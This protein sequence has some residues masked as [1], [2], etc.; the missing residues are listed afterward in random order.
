MA[1]GATSSGTASSSAKATAAQHRRR[2]ASSPSSSS[3]TPS[4][5][6]RL[7]VPVVVEQPPHRD[8]EPCELRRS[9]RWAAP[10]RSTSWAAGPDA[11]ART[12]ADRGARGAME[13]LPP[14]ER[15]ERLNDAAGGDPAGSCRPRRSSSSRAASRRGASP[16]AAA[17]RRCSGTCCAPA[18][19]R[20][21]TRGPPSAGRAR[22]RSPGAA[23]GIVLDLRDP[24]RAAPAGVGLRSGR[25]RQ[26]PRRRPRRRRAARG[27]RR[28]RVREPG[29]RRPRGRA[30][31][32]TSRGRS[33]SST[34][35]DPTPLAVVQL[36][37][38][39]GRHL[40]PAPPPL[41][42]RPGVA[43]HLIDPRRAARATPRWAPP[44][45]SPRRGGRR[46]VLA[47]A[48]F[49]AGPSGLATFDRLGVAVC[50][51]TSTARS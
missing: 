27:G 1:T 11:H 33:R 16:P 8:L 7:G 34:R 23:G 47:K 28:R 35:P 22:R 15:G 20:A 32:P 21:S 42:D 37:R 12:V 14:D 38:R 39:R 19:R 43:H 4:V 5:E 29:R 3:S 49:L 9:G 31:H 30:R 44:R 45:W 46:E 10:P 48:A 6:H 25:D 2:P 51:S 18:T 41:V 36:T 26:G 13:P 50:S 24:H 17:T 40:E